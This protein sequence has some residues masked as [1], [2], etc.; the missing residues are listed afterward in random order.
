MEHRV[1]ILP[2]PSDAPTKRQHVEPP[3]GNIGLQLFL[4]TLRQR[5]PQSL[6]TRT[7]AAT[8]TTPKTAT[9]SSWSRSAREIQLGKFGIRAN[10]TGKHSQILEARST[11]LL[12]NTDASRFAIDATLCRPNRKLTARWQMTRFPSACASSGL[13]LLPPSGR[14]SAAIVFRE[15]LIPSPQEGGQGIIEGAQRCQVER[16]HRQ[17]WTQDCL[18]LGRGHGWSPPQ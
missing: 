1:P 15:R 8:T 4:P 10:T 18:F 14:G 13:V 12:T 5:L 2:H 17:R 3:L 7:I 11:T 9:R 6:T 16:I